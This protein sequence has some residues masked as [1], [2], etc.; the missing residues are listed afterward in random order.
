MRGARWPYDRGSE[1]RRADCMW[2]LG[3]IVPLVPLSQYG[4]FL[5]CQEDMWI[6]M[7]P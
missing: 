5:G 7:K 4:A 2:S 1:T 3:A 6:V